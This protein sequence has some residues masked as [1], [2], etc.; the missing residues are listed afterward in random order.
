M[1]ANALKAGRSLAADEQGSI[2]PMF[3]LLFMALVMFAGIA[4]DYGRS[5]HAQTRLAAAAD[6][7]ALAAGRAMLDGRLSDSDVEELGLKYFNENVQSGGFGTISNVDLVLD[8][9]SGTVRIDVDADV[10]MT[11]TRAGGFESVAVPASSSV[12]AGQQDIELGMALDVTGSMSGSKIADLRTAAKDLVDILIPDTDTPNRIRIGLAPYAASV[13]AGA[14][15]GPVTNGA[16]TNGCVHERGGAAA[17][18]DATPGAGTWLGWTSGLR[19]PTSTIVPLTDDK[20]TLKANIDTYR[21]SGSTAGHIGTHWAWNLISPEWAG[22]WPGAS[23]PAAYNDGKTL[24]AIV[25]MTDGEFNTQY[26]RRNGDSAS[27]ARRLCS[28]MKLKNVVVFAVGFMAP[29]E[30]ED[31]LK[32][33]ASTENHYFNASNGN[34]LRAAFI[35]IAQ[36]LNNLRLTQ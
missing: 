6:A 28:N 30:A 15:A 10:P 19:C 2:A 12:M 25:L 13:N 31:L 9:S 14:Y 5:I 29:E 11:I 4:V 3:G 26:V 36:Q 32:D 35:E 7:A 33:C 8:R 27:Q 16:S 17:F 24:K 20:A 21:A 23:E 34:E 22:I 1:K 18:S